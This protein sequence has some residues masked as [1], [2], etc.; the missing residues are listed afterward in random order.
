MESFWADAF[1][2]ER[3]G[4]VGCGSE[5]WRVRGSVGVG[6]RGCERKMSG[7]EKDES[8]IGGNRIC[9]RERKGEKKGGEEQSR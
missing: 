3:E 7:G 4:G 1:T 5:R 8:E 9:V 6:V 2:A